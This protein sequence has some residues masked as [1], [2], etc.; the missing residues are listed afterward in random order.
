MYADDGKLYSEDGFT[1]DKRTRDRGGRVAADGT[2][3]SV[4]ELESLAIVRWLKG[5]VVT[6][7]V[8]QEVS[9]QSFSAAFTDSL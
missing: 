5:S 4:P 2:G 9:D 7:I 8:D 1:N 3:V 6:C